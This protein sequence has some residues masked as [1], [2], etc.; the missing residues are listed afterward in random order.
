MI[1]LSVLHMFA[2]GGNSGQTLII[3]QGLSLVANMISLS[4]THVCI[5]W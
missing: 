3:E 4:F 5:G 1:K 2:L